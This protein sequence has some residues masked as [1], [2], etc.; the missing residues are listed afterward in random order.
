MGGRSFVGSVVGRE[1][2]RSS[3]LSLSSF[4]DAGLGGVDFLLGDISVAVI[5]PEG[6]GPEVLLLP[7]LPFPEGH[8]GD[9]SASVV[10][11]HFHRLPVLLCHQSLL[12]QADQLLLPEVVEGEGRADA[13]D[14]VLL[15]P[16]GL[17][18]VVVGQQAGL[19]DLHLALAEPGDGVLGLQHHLHAGLHLMV[20]VDVR[21]EA[22][23]LHGIVVTGVPG[24]EVHS[25]GVDLSKDW[26]TSSL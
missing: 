7:V 23:V 16:T 14:V 13:H 1:A 11:G 26:R 18:A 25:V 12:F 2:L 8:V 10:E 20:G 5:S 24:V 19:V 22:G 17:L 3:V 15:L 6:V 4:L 21:L 9:G